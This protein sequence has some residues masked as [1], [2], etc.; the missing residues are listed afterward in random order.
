MS[1][2]FFASPWALGLFLPRGWGRVFLLFFS[3]FGLIFAGAR[4]YNNG[5]DF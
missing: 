5:R 4:V 1:C 2:N 3:F